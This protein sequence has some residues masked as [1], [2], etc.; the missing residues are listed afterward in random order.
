MRFASLVFWCVVFCHHTL[1]HA[2]LSHPGTWQAF[3][4]D[5]KFVFVMISPLPMDED[6]RYPEDAE[7]IEWIRRTYAK[8]GLYLNNDSNK[9]LWE[10]DGGWLVQSIIIALDGE[11][12]ILPGDWT[13]H[14]YRSNAVTFMRRGQT[15]RHY[16]DSDIIPH[17]ILKTVLNGFAPP[18]CAAT[19]FDPDQ[20]TYTIRTN[21]GEEIV[22]D[23][24]TGDISDRRS[25]F[26]TIYTLSVGT[27]LALVAVPVHRWWRNCRRKRT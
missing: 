20:M 14:K 1:A 21:Q 3:S 9:L 19:S 4:D 5:D 7:E 18:S 12:L 26:T 17:W 16:Y 2:G 8:S 15:L 11:H 22:F 13:W 24:T 10:Y 27:V 6:I 25:P 23:V